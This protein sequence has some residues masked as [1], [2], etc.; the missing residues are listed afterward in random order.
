MIARCRAKMTIIQ[1]TENNVGG[2]NLLSQRGLKG[3]II[4]FPQDVSCIAHTLPP[5]LSELAA[6]VCIIFVGSCKP[7]DKWLLEKAKPL[8]I[9][10]QKVRRALEWLKA[11]NNL[12]REVVIDFGAL[13]SLPP[14]SQLPVTIHRYEG[15][16][17][18]SSLSS[19]YDRS[20]NP[21]SEP[22]LPEDDLVFEKTCVPEAVDLSSPSALR[23]A[24][25]NHLKKGGQYIQVPHRD[26]PRGEFKDPT[27]IPMIYPTLFP[28]GLGGFE[29]QRRSVPLSFEKQIQ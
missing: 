24:A 19:G 20:R 18:M 14:S 22:V 3:N 26:T 10:P 16:D 17:E 5:S 21:I 9:R 11:N 27:L 28:Y 6:P 13:D 2:S 25:A 29:H 4:V 15:V 12:Y 23:T 1:M 8:T 7:S